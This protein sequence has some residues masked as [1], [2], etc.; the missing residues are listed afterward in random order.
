MLSGLERDWAVRDSAR[1]NA[2]CLSS[3]H[4]APNANAVQRPTAD[5]AA[6]YAGVVRWLLILPVVSGCYFYA[7]NVTTSQVA[8]SE[9]RRV[10]MTGVASGTP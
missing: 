4:S 7:K 9:V 2:D 8:S 5:P 1:S 3:T 6:R 10:P